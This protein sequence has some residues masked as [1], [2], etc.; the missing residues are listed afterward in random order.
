MGYNVQGGLDSK[1]RSVVGSR[2]GMVPNEAV[3]NE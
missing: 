2:Y 3:S 1:Y